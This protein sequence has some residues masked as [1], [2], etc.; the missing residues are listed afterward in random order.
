MEKYH[1]ADQSILI[2]LTPQMQTFGEC[3]RAVRDRPRKLEVA[4]FSGVISSDFGGNRENA[5][6]VLQRVV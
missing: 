6:I 3:M 5:Q 2:N 4:Y 1:E